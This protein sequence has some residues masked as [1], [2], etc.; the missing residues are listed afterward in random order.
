MCPVL[1]LFAGGLAEYVQA[2]CSPTVRRGRDQLRLLSVKPVTG[3]WR[4]LLFGR[5]WCIGRAEV[6]ADLVSANLVSAVSG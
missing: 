3:L 2:V 6:S 5:L 4:V 1:T